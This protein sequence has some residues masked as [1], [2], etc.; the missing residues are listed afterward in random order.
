MIRV[1]AMRLQMFL[2]ADTTGCA[3]LRP[4]GF[5]GHARGYDHSALRACRVCVRSVLSASR[6]CVRSVLGAM[7][8]CVYSA[9]RA[10][11]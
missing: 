7:R 11:V 1:A 10:C 2:L 8:G 4:T 9:L 6:G 5:A 3:P